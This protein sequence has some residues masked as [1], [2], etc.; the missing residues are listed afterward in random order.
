MV[1]IK[2]GESV[3]EYAASNKA[4]AYANSKDVGFNINFTI[5]G[6]S[7]S[8]SNSKYL[9]IR[10]SFFVKQKKFSIIYFLTIKLKMLAIA[11]HG[12]FR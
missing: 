12:L 1:K 7:A 8:D 2:T 10:A 3:Y 4:E 5:Q 6:V 9:K 11:I